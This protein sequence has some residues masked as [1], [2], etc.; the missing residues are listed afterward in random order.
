MMSENPLRSLKMLTS[1]CGQATMPRIAIG[2]TMW[3]ELPIEETGV[4]QEQ[5]LAVYWSELSPKS[6]KECHLERFNDSV[7]SAWTV[8]GKLDRKNSA[9]LSNDN[10]TEVEQDLSMF[11]LDQQELIQK[12]EAQAAK[13]KDHPVLAA[14]IE[15]EKVEVEDQIGVVKPSEEQAANQKDPELPDEL[16]KQMAEVKRRIAVV[17]KLLQQLKSFSGRLRPILSNM[18][19]KRRLGTIFSTGPPSGDKGI[20]KKRVPGNDIFIACVRIRI[21]NISYSRISFVL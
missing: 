4:R 17:Q 8:I 1:L 3:S 18:I 14:E 11:L 13:Q 7:D 10:V 6:P 20:P 16:K 15:L 9:M 21:S 19:P 2:T 5:A 12:L